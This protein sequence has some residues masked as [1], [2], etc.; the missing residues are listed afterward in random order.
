[1]DRVTAE[2][3]RILHDDKR[4]P[5]T[6]FPGKLYGMPDVAAFH[7]ASFSGDGEGL[8]P[9]NRRHGAG[10]EKM[11]VAVGFDRDQVSGAGTDGDGYLP[12]HGA[13]G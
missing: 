11:V 9:R 1:M 10:L 12:G 2:I 4:N 13:R 7:Q 8:G 3:R 6:V 5:P